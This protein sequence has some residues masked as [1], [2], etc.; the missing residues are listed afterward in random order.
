MSGEAMSEERLAELRRKTNS[1]CTC[2]ID[3]CDEY[4]GS[5]SR[6]EANAV[7]DELDRLRVQLGKPR[8]EWTLGDEHGPYDD[9][10]NVRSEADVRY[11]VSDSDGSSRAWRRLVGQW[12][13]ADGQ[14]TRNG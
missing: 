8:V 5:L 1:A 2:G 13:K 9:T 12:R 11:W 6:D 10:N 4:A 3:D 14:E 7:L